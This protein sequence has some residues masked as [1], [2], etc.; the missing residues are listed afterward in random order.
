M[1]M[2]SVAVLEP[3]LPLA[4]QERQRFPGADLAGGVGAMVDERPDR[5]EPVA[6]L[7]RRRGL[8]LLAVCGHQR[9]VHIDDQ[10]PRSARLAI[11]GVPAGG[12]P[13]GPTGRGP[14][15]VDR[16]QR[17]LRVRGERVDQP[18]DRRVRPDQP[19]HRWLPPQHGDIRQAV[20]AHRQRHREIEQDLRWV[21]HRGR[22]PPPRQRGP[23]LTVQT[24]RPDRLQQQHRAGLRHTPNAALVDPNPG[25]QAGRVLHQKGAPDPCDDGPQQAPSFQVRST[26]P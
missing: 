7:E 4:E 25:I 17:P 2:W 6:L 23:Q 12:R 1:V 24:G 3:A 14:R 9:R 22:L 8:L 20:P 10:R 21:V 19:E 5:M 16:A 26:F 13:R 18:A 15:R 11:W